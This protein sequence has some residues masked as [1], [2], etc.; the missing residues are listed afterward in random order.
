MVF[1][2]DGNSSA[3][4]LRV[5]PQR[6]HGVYPYRERDDAKKQHRGSGG[7]SGDPGRTHDMGCSPHIRIPEIARCLF[8][9]NCS[10]RL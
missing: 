2:C 4:T 3:I 8:R 10:P 5:A 1:R 7:K 6:D 9:T